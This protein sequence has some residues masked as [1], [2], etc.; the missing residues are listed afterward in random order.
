MRELLAERQEL[1]ET[2]AALGVRLEGM[3]PPDLQPISDRLNQL[4]E[5]L[6]TP[7][8]VDLQSLHERIDGLS[9]QVAAAPTVDLTPIQAQVERLQ[10][11]VSEGL[12]A[13]PPVDDSDVQGE[14]DRL[15]QQVDSLRTALIDRL[16]AL[17]APDLS[18]LQEHLRK[19]DE[20]VAA[21]PAPDLSP[22]QEELARLA[23]QVDA[24][25][26][27]DQ[28][29]GALA[30]Q[31]EALQASTESDAVIEAVEAATTRLAG[32]IGGLPDQVSVV[33]E[34]L[35]PLNVG[36]EQL[37]Q[38]DAAVRGD[39]ALV[40][41]V[42]AGL[43]QMAESDDEQ[44]SSLFAAQLSMLNEQRSLISEAGLNLSRSVSTEVQALASQL[45]DVAARVGALDGVPQGLNETRQALT[46]L[47][48]RADHA[49]DAGREAADAHALSLARVTAAADGLATGLGS[50]RAAIGAAGEATVTGVDE[51]VA[52]RL[53]GIATRLDTDLATVREQLADLGITQ[54]RVSV[55]ELAQQVVDARTDDRSLRDAIDGLATQVA[56]GRTDDRKLRDAVSAV[57]G[58][59]T[60]SNSD[61]IQP[62]TTAIDELR[63]RIDALPTPDLGAV[64]S[65]LARLSATIVSQNRGEAATPDHVDALRQSVEA[66]LQQMTAQLDA[67]TQAAT[68]MRTQLAQQLDTQILAAT[69]EVRALLAVQS[70]TPEPDAELHRVAAGLQT[71]LDGISAELEATRK[72]AERRSGSRSAPRRG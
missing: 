18:P 27:A 4:G 71:T 56:E 69:A 37:V 47:T 58:Q 62:L 24:L 21:A 29:A 30:P 11:A 7:P 13:A 12:A 44:M 64:A 51:R 9:Q 19:L 53:A 63:A 45:A 66:S 22:L 49:D 61:G 67:Q 1:S 59:I 48:T 52:S 33:S 65:Q 68:E 55:A 34:V 57:K 72:A 60:K 50:L 23:A 2:L 32:Q 31:L 26:R 10:S 28:V 39:L 40:T 5:E 14:L 42:L 35:G 36:I 25:P 6:R 70:T 46:A 8:T 17:P 15:N 16:E 54:L 43:T 38:S 20:R 3:G 41:E